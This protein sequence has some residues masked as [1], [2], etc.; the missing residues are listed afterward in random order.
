MFLD[1]NSMHIQWKSNQPD[2]EKQ[3]R[4]Y[5][6]PEHGE[7][8]V[9]WC[10]W[11]KSEAESKDKRTSLLGRRVRA[12]KEGTNQN[13]DKHSRDKGNT[14]MW[15]QAVHSREDAS[16]IHWITIKAR[17]LQKTS[18]CFIDYA[19][20]LW[21]H[22]S[23]QSLENSE[24]VGIPEHLSCLLRNLYAGHEATVRTGHGTTDWFQTRKGVRQGCILSP[25]LFNIHAECIMRNAGC[26]KHKL[27]WRLP[28]E[29]LI[30]S[31]MQMT[32]HLWQKLKN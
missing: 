19:K 2:K 3:L 18:S 20:A 10:W 4:F 31:N 11:I 8:L 6:S 30:T 12:N 1:F 21:W 17:E 24:E 23:Q 29:I 26:M 16:S 9:L 22:G 15:E 32:P 25:C 27:G 14:Q 5:Y 13:S 28:G 7:T